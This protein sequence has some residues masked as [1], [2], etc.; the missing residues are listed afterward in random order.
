MREN[1]MPFKRVLVT[2]GAGFV[3]YRLVRELSARG[4]VSAPL[5]NLLVGMPLPASSET[6]Y[7]FRAD[8]RDVA[9]IDRI[10]GEFKPDIVV[11]LAAVHHIPT[12]EKNPHLAMDVNVMGTQTLLD[13][14][15]K[16]GVSNF[17]LASSA[18]VYDWADGAL[19]EDETPLRATDVYSTGKLCNEYQLRTWAGRTG[20]SGAIAR[21]FNVIGHDDPN[22]H[23][24]PDIL[25]QLNISNGKIGTPRVHL[26]N[27]AP[28]RDY[29]HADDTARG[30]LAIVERHRWE[31]GVQAYNV[32][33][34]Q[35]HSVGDLVAL[36]GRRFGSDI[37]IVRD[38]SRVRRVDRLHLWGDQTKVRGLLEWQGRIPIEDAMRD[39]LARLVS[40]SERGEKNGSDA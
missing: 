7:P 2:G 22:G 1:C 15:A 37:E 9:E 4:I 13:A 25:A 36:I 5:D 33:F 10:F 17:L 11:H 30:L 19:V 34:G 39:I 38:E 24:I 6:S 8:I 35:E 18:A 12:C 29:T 27:T 23:L 3:G 16:H 21:I 26:G 31:P 28:K 32:S 40:V 14:S 20:G